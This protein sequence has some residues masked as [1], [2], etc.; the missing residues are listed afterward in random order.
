MKLYDVE[1]VLSVAK[2]GRV[3]N[4]SKWIENMYAVIGDAYN[5]DDWDAYIR[6]TIIDDYVRLRNRGQFVDNRHWGCYGPLGEIF[7]E[8]C[9]V[10]RFTNFNKE[11]VVGSTPPIAAM[12]A[13]YSLLCGNRALCESA[14][15]NLGGDLEL[16]ELSFDAYLSTYTR[17]CEEVGGPTAATYPEAHM[18]AALIVADM[19]YTIRSERVPNM[20]RLHMGARGD[21]KRISKI[22]GDSFAN[23]VGE[24]ATFEMSVVEYRGA[25]P[26]IENTPRSM[27]KK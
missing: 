22:M 25:L 23:V 3:K 17:V 15:D 4:L 11:L 19:S 21:F 5:V 2:D 13:A 6:T 9:Y 24:P 26:H 7:R 14:M 10:V 20:Q 16:V 8:P 12:E 27:E 1:K 18:L